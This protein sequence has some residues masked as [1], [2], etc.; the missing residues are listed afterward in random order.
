MIFYFFQK[1]RDVI[2]YNV[3]QYFVIDLNI[4]MSNDISGTIHFCL[5]VIKKQ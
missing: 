4:C 3:P 1:D 2:T 5:C